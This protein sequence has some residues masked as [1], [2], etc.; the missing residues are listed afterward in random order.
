MKIFYLFFYLVMTIFLVWN[1]IYRKKIIN[2]L[3][4]KIDFYVLK[5]KFGTKNQ[6]FENIFSIISL[7][8][9][10]I[11]FI[12]VDKT[13]NEVIITNISIYAIFIFNFYCFIKKKYYENL[14]ITNSVLLLIG[15]S[16]FN[17][18]DIN[19]YLYITYIAF[20]SLVLIFNNKTES[21]LS[22]EKMMK[23]LDNDDYLF[24]SNYS[25]RLTTRI[26]KR[27]NS[28]FGKSIFKIIDTFYFI[29]LLLIFSNFYFFQSTVPTGSMLPT[30]PLNSRLIVNMGVYK[31]FDAKRNDVAIFKEPTQ[32]K[33]YYVKRIKGTPGD[34]IKIQGNTLFINGVKDTSRIYTPEGIASNYSIYIPKKGDVI[35]LDKIISIHREIVEDENGNKKIFTDYNNSLGKN[36]EISL[37]IFNINRTKKASEIFASEI[38]INSKKISPYYTFILRAKNHDEVVLPI[39]DLKFDNSKMEELLSGNEIVLNQDNFLMLGDNTTNSLDGRY[40]GTIQKNHLKGKIEFMIYPLIQKIE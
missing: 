35:T 36:E 9:T 18:T 27:R 24:N 5:T 33:V 12:K 1:I 17:I 3:R 11:C 14:V 28:L 29:F 30:L 15:K 20:I 25:K 4:E 6:I 38:N 31:L 26:L 34:V 19:F 2:F 23:E 21:K 32:R 40:F 13:P 8:I 22:Y 7:I 10:I 37:E 16:M 39:M